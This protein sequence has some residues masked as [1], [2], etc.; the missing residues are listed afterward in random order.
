MGFSLLDQY[1]YLHF[2]SGIIAYHWSFGFAAWMVLHFVFEMLENTRPSV[3]FIDNYL[4]F[5]WPGGKSKPDTWAN[6]IGDNVAAAIGWG[7]A[8]L[9]D[10]YGK[11]KGWYHT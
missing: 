4:S 2:A 9:L 6:I 5:I 1:S 7:S 3:K 11:N 8:F 10:R